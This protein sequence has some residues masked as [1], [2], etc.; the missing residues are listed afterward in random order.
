VWLIAFAILPHS[1]RGVSW[2]ARSVAEL[3]NSGVKA[4]G[5]ENENR[6]GRALRPGGTRPDFIQRGD[7]QNGPRN[8]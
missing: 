3:W 1:A 6:R 4:V 7:D 2:T 8:F 5:V